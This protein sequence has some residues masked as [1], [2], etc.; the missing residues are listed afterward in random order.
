MKTVERMRLEILVDDRNDK[1]SLFLLE[2]RILAFATAI[3]N[4]KLY[5][6]YATF[7][8]RGSQL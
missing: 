7:L 2:L 8:S 1:H 5:L 6:H 3:I 4:R